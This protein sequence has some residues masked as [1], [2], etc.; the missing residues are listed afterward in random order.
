MPDVRQVA[1]RTFAVQYTRRK[2][3]NIDGDSMMID[4]NDLFDDDKLPPE[5]IGRSIIV[6]FVSLCILGFIGAVVS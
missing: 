5:W 1:E 2:S 3:S 6:L 4:D